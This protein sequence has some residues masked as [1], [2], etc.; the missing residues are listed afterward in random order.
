MHPLR[1]TVWCIISLFFFKNDKRDN[2]N[3][4]R[5]RNRTIF[6]D[7]SFAEIENMDN[8]FHQDRDTIKVFI[9]FEER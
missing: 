7:W 1:V 2:I 8:C 6:T 9:L 4:N 5:E 3:V